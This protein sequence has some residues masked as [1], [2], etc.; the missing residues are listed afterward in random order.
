[1]Y[2]CMICFFLKINKVKEALRSVRIR[3]VLAFPSCGDYI[4]DCKEMKL[5]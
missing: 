3:T 4:M 2:S 5:P 1:M